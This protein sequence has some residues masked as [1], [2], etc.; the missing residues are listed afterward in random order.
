MEWSLKSGPREFVIV[1]D[2]FVVGRG[3]DVDLPIDDES[4]SR[5]HAQFR[6]DDGQPVV[7]DLQSRNGTL[8]NRRPI[9]GRARL[10]VG[11]RIAF[12]T[13]ELELLRACPT[14]PFAL[15]PPTKPIVR[16]MIDM[17]PAPGTLAAL[18]P[19]ER[20]IFGLLAEGLSQR[21]IAEHFKVSVKTVETYRTRIG[22][23]LGLRNRAELIR[24][25]LDAGVL[26]PS[27]PSIVRPA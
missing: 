24:C 15:E 27:R 19:R 5:R 18:S 7:E 1:A 11:D 2:A 4:V 23:K 8:V 26:R 17:T 10:S 20:E 6:L 22:Q 21:E 12:G 16:D 25:A 13:C 9:V 14:P 3:P